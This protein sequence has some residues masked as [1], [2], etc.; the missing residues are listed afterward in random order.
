MGSRARSAS[1][2]LALFFGTH[3]YAGF[4]N[5]LV[6]ALALAGLLGILWEL[7]VVPGHGVPGILGVLGAARVDFAR[8]WVPVFLHRHRNGVD[9]DDLDRDL[10]CAC[11]AALSAERMDASPGAGR[12]SGL[13][14][15]RPAA[16]SRRCAE[17]RGVASSY[18]RPAGV[19]LIGD[20]RVD[21]L[22]EG[23]FIAAGTPVK[24]TRVEG[25]RI[26]VEPT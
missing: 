15:R 26:F 16:I 17:R 5:G 24:V 12:R 4:S 7:H 14:L 20:R 13:G 22:T 21:V 1:R 10:L 25:A 2:A 18:L 11:D 23:E 6:I 3:I 9:V 8:V 19:A